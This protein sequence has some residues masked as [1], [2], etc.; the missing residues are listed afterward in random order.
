MWGVL[1][2]AKV[3]WEVDVGFWPNY[4]EEALWAGRGV[5]KYLFDTPHHSLSK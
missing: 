2:Y 4:G 1:V 5:G 3:L